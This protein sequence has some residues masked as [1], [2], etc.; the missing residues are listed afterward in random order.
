[1]SG[2]VLT[3][4]PGAGKTAILRLLELDGY[5]VVEEAATDVIAVDQAL[6]Q[7]ELADV[8]A[9]IDRIVLLQRRRQTGTPVGNGATVVFDRS[10]ICTLALSRYAQVA[11]S[12]LLRA[13]LDRILAQRMYE[14]TVFFVRN[15]GFIQPTATRRISFADALRF[16]RIHEDTYTELGFRLIEIPAA[17]L[18]TRVALVKRTITELQT[19]TQRP[20]LRR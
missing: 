4:T 9:F 7:D 14:P 10:P 18:T 6:G 3:G 19:Q 13:E 15:Q 1:M 11:P 20:Q 16:E 8:P 2:Y 5:T 17:P 12:R